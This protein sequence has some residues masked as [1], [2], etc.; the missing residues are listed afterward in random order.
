MSLATIILWQ[1]AVGNNDV[2]APLQDLG[3]AGNLTIT[4]NVGPQNALAYPVAPQTMPKGPYYM[5]GAN[6]NNVA[7][8]VLITSPDDLSGV[9]FTITGL[10]SAVDTD[11]N[12]T[13]PLNQPISDTI[14]GPNNSNVET[15]VIFKRVDS[16]A[17]DGAVT[18][19]SA[20]LGTTGI[21]TYIFPDYDRRAWYASCSVQVLGASSIQYTAYQSLNKPSYPGANTGNFV[22]FIGGEIPAFAVATSM[23]GATD[24]QITKLDFPIASLWL[25]IAETNPLTAN[26][27]IFTFLQQ[28]IK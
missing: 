3:G 9:D 8:T 24:N 26:S 25:S 2:I 7:R 17:A 22:P 11:G 5:G 4:T 28:G 10:G 15:A 1:P 13:G 12:P 19:V 27:L 6:P 14:G 23:T 21:T 18:N 20:G 16:I